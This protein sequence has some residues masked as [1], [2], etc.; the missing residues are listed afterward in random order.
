MDKIQYTWGHWL[1][2][3]ALLI[4]LFFV[5]RFLGRWLA[6]VGLWG[7]YHEGVLR[8]V[9]FI[10]LIYEPVALLILTVGFIFINPVYHG[11]GV[12]LLLVVGFSHLRDYLHG[13][14]VRSDGRIT[15]DVQMSTANLE[16]IVSATGRLGLRLKN[17]QGLHYVP[18]SKLLRQ[19]FVLHH[20]EQLGGFY[21]LKIYPKEAEDKIEEGGIIIDRLISAPYLD[22]ERKPDIDFSDKNKKQLYARI[23]VKEEGQLYELMALIDEW[24]YETEIVE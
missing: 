13:W 6:N 14:I 5:L 15:T 1:L 16:G 23:S 17:N 20:G 18:Y 4:T 22:W 3:L 8:T 7:K 10:L 11:V 2:A 19:G 21:K 24:G 12:G 9:S